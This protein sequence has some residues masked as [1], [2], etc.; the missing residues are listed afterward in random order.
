MA[1]L[2]KPE[3]VLSKNILLTMYPLEA[4]RLII[5]DYCSRSPDVRLFKSGLFQVVPTKG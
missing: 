2:P 3:Y 4:A 5:P 1:N